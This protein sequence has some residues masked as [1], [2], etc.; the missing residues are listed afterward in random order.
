MTDWVTW[1]GGKKAAKPGEAV[2]ASPCWRVWA[3]RVQARVGND[4][5]LDLAAFRKL[6][7][8]I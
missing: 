7:G 4:H 2:K 5:Q 6:L 3:G 1:P 8:R